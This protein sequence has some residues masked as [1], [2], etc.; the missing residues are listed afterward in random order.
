VGARSKV[1]V[2]SGHRRLGGVERDAQSPLPGAPT[3]GVL[4]WGFLEM[5]QVNE[6]MR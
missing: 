2:V 1:D 3:A 6:A 5:G 4:E